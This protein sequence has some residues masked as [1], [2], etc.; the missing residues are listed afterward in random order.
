MTSS[1]QMSS[2]EQTTS[3]EQMTSSEQTTLSESNEKFIVSAI[4]FDFDGDRTLI[5]MVFLPR[6]VLSPKGATQKLPK[7]F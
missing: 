6:T 3:S 5:L 7:E 4:N 1:E 2:S